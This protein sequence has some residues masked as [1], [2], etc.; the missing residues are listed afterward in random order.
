V[1]TLAADRQALL[2]AAV[3]DEIGVLS[4]KLRGE[5]TATFKWQ[6]NRRPN[7]LICDV[8]H[9]K[10][11]C[12]LVESGLT[13]GGRTCPVRKASL[14]SVGVSSQHANREGPAKRDGSHGSVVR[15]M[16]GL[17]SGL[18]EE[19]KDLSLKKLAA[20]ADRVSPL[21]CKVRCK[22]ASE[23]AVRIGKPISVGFLQ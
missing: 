8:V 23:D 15:P 3:R 17:K 11:S 19:C 9:C 7:V 10:F 13:N 14:P 4:H 18:R 22:V 20:L 6:G 2:P 1:R 16:P 12:A 5:G 21:A